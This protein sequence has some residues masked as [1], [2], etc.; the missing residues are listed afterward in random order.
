MFFYDL[1]F[2]FAENLVKIGLH[3][4]LVER[5]RKSIWS[6]LKRMSPKFFDI[7]IF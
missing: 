4:D 7:Y 2:L 6:T 1:F 3:I 5:R